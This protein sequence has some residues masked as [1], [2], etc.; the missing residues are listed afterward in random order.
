M[1]NSTKAFLIAG[2]ILV[3]ILIIAIGMFI[4]NSATG[5]TTDAM[6][7][8]STQEIDV[9]NKQFDVYEG[10]QNGSQIK[11]LM[12]ILIS[13]A[14]SNKDNPTKIPGVGINKCVNTDQKQMHAPV[15][16]AGDISQYIEII[17]QIRNKLDKKHDYWVE[18]TYQSNGLVDYITITYDAENPEAT[19]TR[20]HLDFSSL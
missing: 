6:S 1:E 16:D 9:F 20:D 5:T 2:A 15:P 10:L 11:S 18:L 12:G 3:A 8:M 17:G 7:S 19:Y 14:N 4:N 13:N